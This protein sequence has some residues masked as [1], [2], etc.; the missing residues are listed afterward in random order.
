MMIRT[1]TPR[2]G[3]AR[4]GLT[5]T[6]LLKFQVIARILEPLRLWSIA[7]SSLALIVSWPGLLKERPGWGWNLSMGG[8]GLPSQWP[9][10]AAV[11]AIEMPPGASAW[12][13]VTVASVA[14][15]AAMLT[16]AMVTLLVVTVSL[17][18]RPAQATV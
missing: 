6:Q 14:R 13:A 3:A 8:L 15:T 12:A 7:R 17:L 11:C 2:L 18:C 16:T 9:W 1:L 4:R 10:S 5:K